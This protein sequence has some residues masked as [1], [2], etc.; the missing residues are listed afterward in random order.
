MPTDADALVARAKV[1]H[2]RARKAQEEARRIAAMVQAETG[3]GRPVQ[4]ATDVVV[5]QFTGGAR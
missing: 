4:A 2:A 1:M 3:Y 5:D